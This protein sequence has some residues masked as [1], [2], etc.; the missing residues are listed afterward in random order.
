MTQRLI[1]HQKWEMFSNFDD[2]TV[3]LFNYGFIY[4]TSTA[5]Y[6]KD[7]LKSNC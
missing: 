7:I 4:Y 3:K 5:E 2:V 1:R 6:I